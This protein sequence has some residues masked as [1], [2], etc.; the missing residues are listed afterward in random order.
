MHQLHT[1]KVTTEVAQSFYF[2]PYWTSLRNSATQVPPPPL[3]PLGH[4]WDVMLVWRKGNIQCLK[5]NRTAII[6]D[7]TS[8]LFTT[9]TNY[10]WHR[11]TLFN[12]PLTTI[13]FL[14]WHRTSCVVSIT[15]VATWHLNSGFLGRLRTTYH[16]QA[17]NEWQD[18]CGAVSMSSFNFWYRTFYY[19]DRNTV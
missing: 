6:N 19:S 17:I 10:F 7:L 13:K 4:I 8:P 11:E 15:T 12:S 16:R 5:K 1:H 9:F 18:D 3:P 2:S 14:S